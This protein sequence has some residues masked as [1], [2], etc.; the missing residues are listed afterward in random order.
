MADTAPILELDRVQK[1]FGVRSGSLAD[2]LLRR[3]R[4]WVRAVDDVTFDLAPG[5]TVGVVGESGCGKTTLGRLVL[6]DLKPTAGDV[7]FRG[8]SLPAMSRS[9]RRAYQRSVATVFQDPFSSLNPRHRVRSVVMEPVTIHNTLKDDA[10]RERLDEML[11]VVGLP[12]SAANLFPHEF[13]G[14]QRQRI[15]IARALSINPSLIVLDEPISALD[16]SIRAQIINLLK[17]IQQ[18]FGPAYLFIA[19]DLASVYHMTDR[20]AV[21]YLGKVVEIGDTVSVYRQPAHPYS[22]ALISAALPIDPRRR[23]EEE[24]LSG[25]VPSPIDPPSGCRFHPR[26]PW[27]IDRCRTEEP[28]LADYFGDGRLVACH[29]AREVGAE[30]LPM[31]PQIDLSLPEIG[32]EPRPA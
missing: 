17:D 18:E 23:D 10:A 19:H 12:R 31:R 22:R 26:C 5:E 25:E 2:L 27:E 3:A 16:V 8:Q 11:D 7:R 13:S 29:R 4:R 20:V 9:E 24:V 14:G 1:H 15:A 28:Q 30:A 32:L 6:G 21:M